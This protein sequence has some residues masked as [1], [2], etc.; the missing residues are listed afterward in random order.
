MTSVKGKNTR[1]L[2]NSGYPQKS[3]YYGYKVNTPNNK[4]KNNVYAAFKG[5]FDKS[6]KTKND[7]FQ[8]PYDKCSELINQAIDNFIVKGKNEK[9]YSSIIYLQSRSAHAKDLANRIFSR[10]STK[11]RTL[12]CEVVE[13]KKFQ[14]FN[15]SDITQVFNIDKFANDCFN[16]IGRQC[17]S[18]KDRVYFYEPKIREFL[19]RYIF[20]IVIYILRE[21][22]ANRAKDQG[23]SIASHI[24]SKVNSDIATE[25]FKN[26]KTR[27]ETFFT[28][29]PEKTKINMSG[30][31]DLYQKDSHYDYNSIVPTFEVAKNET[32]APAVP[33]ILIVDDNINTGDT[34]KQINFII[35]H[36][37]E[38]FGSSQVFNFN[39]FILLKDAKYATSV[40]DKKH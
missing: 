38:K 17:T 9:K 21:H 26:F 30:H 25:V 27:Y 2:I 13:L 4:T 10:L 3:I 5:V 37:R 33:E 15:P 31:L 20:K 6:Y 32:V 1:E 34:F 18:K 22:I 23:I 19:V 7:K 8:L 14:T 24:R 35:K 28:L 16:L 11:R 40:K 12:K 29:C 39:Y 36:L